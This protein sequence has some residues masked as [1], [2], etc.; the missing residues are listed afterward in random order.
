LGLVH[1][2]T[3]YIE[4]GDYKWDYPQF[5]TTTMERICKLPDGA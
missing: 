5:G 1:V 4:D 2:V 3:R